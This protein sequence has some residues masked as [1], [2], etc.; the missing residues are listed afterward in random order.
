MLLSRDIVI[1]GMAHR[2]RAVH[3]DHVVVAVL[4]PEQ[5]PPRIAGDDDAADQDSTIMRKAL[6]GKVRMLNNIPVCHCLD[7]HLMPLKV[8]GILQKKWRDYVCT[9]QEGEVGA[10]V[11][12]KWKIVKPSA[13]CVNRV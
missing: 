6:T 13:A 7:R 1:V 5:Q 9:V 3:G 10:K 12:F 8:V 11:C 4:P 2:N